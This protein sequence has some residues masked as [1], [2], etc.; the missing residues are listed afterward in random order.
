MLSFVI[1]MSKNRVIGVKNQLPWRLPRDLKFFSQVTDGGVVIMGSK[2]FESL[3]PSH[4]PLPN[5]VNIVLTREDRQFEGAITAHTL[6]EAIEMAKTKSTKDEY[7]VIGGGQVFAQALPIADR[8]YLTIVDTVIEN[9]EAFFPELNDAD[10]DIK[11][12]GHFE[13]DA[14]HQYDGTWYVY[15]RRKDG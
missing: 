6:D 5:R 7:F 4:K 12:I 3:P 15:D 10:W 2:T 9:G 1:A 14:K 8:I 13:K 11:E